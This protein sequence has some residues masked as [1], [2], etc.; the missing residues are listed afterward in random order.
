MPVP[1][2]RD[3][4]DESFEEAARQEWQQQGEDQR[5]QRLVDDV[6]FSIKRKLAGDDGAGLPIKRPR[7]H[8]SWIVQAMTA[9]A[10]SGPA[11]EWVSR[12]ELETLKRLTGLPLSAAR[13]HR[14]PR[15]RLMRP[16]KLVSRSRLSILIGED[17][18]DAFVVEEDEKQVTAEPRR[19]VSVY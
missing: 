9:A 19:K 3:L 16:P 15:K 12:H 17:P 6:P 18:K 10:D 7:I 2:D 13:I 1:E 5:R 8:A 4:E 11:N 14:R